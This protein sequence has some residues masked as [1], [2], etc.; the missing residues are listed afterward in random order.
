[1]NLIDFEVDRYELDNLLT[2]NWDRQQQ[3]WTP[4]PPTLTTFDVLAHNELPVPNDS[5]FLFTGGVGYAVG[6]Q[7]LILGSQI[8]GTDGTYDPTLGLYGNDAIITVEQ[9]DGFGTIQQARAQGLAPTTTVGAVYTNIVGTNI[10]GTGAGATWD[11]V[12]TGEDPTVFDGNSLQ[13]T[14]PVDMFSNTTD[15]DKYLV[16]PKR[17]ILG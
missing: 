2:K 17:T 7:I 12:T 14:A 13:F 5:S 15:F 8:G 16:F 1:L 6:D 4:Q 3:H 11:L 9:V 10:T